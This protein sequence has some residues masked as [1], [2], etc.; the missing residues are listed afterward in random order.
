MNIIVKVN[1]WMA[2]W[3]KII[4]HIKIWQELNIQNI[5]KT[6]ENQQ[7]HCKKQMLKWWKTK[8][9]QFMEGD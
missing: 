3:E 1:R 4:C 8:S 9:T 5:Q 6:P 2:D 7:E